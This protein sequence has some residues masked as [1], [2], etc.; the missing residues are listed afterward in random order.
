MP[1]L[2]AKSKT[3]LACSRPGVRVIRA[4]GNTK[5]SGIDKQMILWLEKIWSMRAMKIRVLCDLE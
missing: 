3:Y 1:L 2:A 5:Q 4:P